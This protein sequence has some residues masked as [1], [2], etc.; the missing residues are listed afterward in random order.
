MIFAQLLWNHSANLSLAITNRNLDFGQQPRC[1]EA[2]FH[3]WNI[4]VRV[5]D[6]LLATLA[7]L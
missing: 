6:F 1:S 4:C 3:F 2:I 7:Y 5:L